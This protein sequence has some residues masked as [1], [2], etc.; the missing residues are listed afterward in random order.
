MEART[1][2]GDNIYT[3]T[4]GKF[5]HTRRRRPLTDVEKLIR[6]AQ[7]HDGHRASDCFAC[8][9]LAGKALRELERRKPRKERM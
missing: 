5:V 3:D 6:H 9:E 1:W 7:A 8:Q 2:V 4:D